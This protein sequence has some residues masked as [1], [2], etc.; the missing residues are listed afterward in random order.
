MVLRLCDQGDQIHTVFFV[1]E[2]PGAVLE[3]GPLQIKPLWITA[4]KGTL[5]CAL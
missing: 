1:P 3:A 5:A 2:V 4:G